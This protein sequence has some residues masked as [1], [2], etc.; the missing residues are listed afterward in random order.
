MKS[1][2][3]QVPEIAG[4]LA[5]FVLLLSA[6]PSFAASSWSS[7]GTASATPAGTSCTNPG[8]GT[9]NSANCGVGVYVGGGTNYS[10]NMTVDAFSTATGTVGA[11]TAGTSFAAASLRQYSSGFGV[12]SLNEDGSQPSHSADNQYG[13]DAI[14]LRFSEQVTLQ[15]VF[16]GWNGTDNVTGGDSDISIFR[17]AG[18]GAPGAVVG[19]NVT[20]MAASGWKLVSNA[21]NVGANGGS[22]SG[23]VG[24]LNVNLETPTATASSYWLI[25]AYNTNFGGN[26]DGGSPKLDYFKLTGIVAQSNGNKTPEP[27]SLALMGVAFAGMMAVRRRKRLIA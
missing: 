2:R 24:T 6:L 12:V 25:S 16:I 4:L 17:W 20:N 27:S 5:G 11:P 13:A 23:S 9:P 14:R 10:V 26:L 3:S 8:T 1:T 21:P 7:M 22:S 15:Q 18:P 19:A